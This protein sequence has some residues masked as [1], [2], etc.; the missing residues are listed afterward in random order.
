MKT[1]IMTTI[2]AIIFLIGVMS[3]VVSADARIINN[4]SGIYINDF[5]AGTTTT[6]NFSYNYLDNYGNE[7]Y[8]HILRI[9]ISSWNQEDYPVWKGDFELDGFVRKYTWF[10][11]YHKDIE[12]ECSEE[13]PLTIDHL[14]GLNV[15][16]VPDGIFYCY[17]TT[18]EAIDNLD[19]HDEVYLTIKS[20]PALWPGKYNLFANLYYLEDTRSPF[21]NITNKDL[22]DLYY[23]ENDNVLVKATI[24]DASG[25]SEKWATVMINGVEVFP[26]NYDHLENSEYY[27]SRNTPEDIVE[28][29]YEL[30]VFAKDEFGNKGNDSVVLKIDRTGPK[31]EALQP[32]GSIYDEI[33]PIELNITDEKAGVNSQSVYYR[34]REMNGTSICPGEGIGTWDCYDSGWVKLDLNITTAET[35]K[36]EINTTGIGL[37]S[38]EYWFEAKA[39][40]ILGNKGILE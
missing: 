9:N 2:L 23:R 18:S 20:H 24:N 29:N 3:V 34:L 19:K 38:G 14:L 7:Q 1:K 26:V 15:L 25:I 13:N 10:G 39:E 32:N 37:E 40:D 22:F 31:I 30:F 5:V 8:P 17:N 11:L 35:Y 33:L 12:L 4:V 16:D 21:V 27:F 36:T 6:A 28:D